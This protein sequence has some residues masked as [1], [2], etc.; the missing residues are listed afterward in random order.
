MK[1][2]RLDIQFTS[3]AEAL[4]KHRS[5]IAFLYFRR[6]HGYLFEQA[7]E[8]RFAKVIWQWESH[9]SGI[10]DTHRPR[11]LTH[12]PPEPDAMLNLVLECESDLNGHVIFDT[13]DPDHF[14]WMRTQDWWKINRKKHTHVRKQKD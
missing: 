1:Q 4:P 10:I 14:W 5:D 6:D 8:V 7:A 12:S 2:I 3:S 13:R 9:S 11:F